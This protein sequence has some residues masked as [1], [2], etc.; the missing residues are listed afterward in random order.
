MALLTVLFSLSV[1]PRLHVVHAMDECL[2]FNGQIVSFT[3]LQ[4]ARVPGE[5]LSSELR[6]DDGSGLSRV[7][8][9]ESSSRGNEAEAR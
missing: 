9:V 4:V 7:Q 2:G 5:N 6:G 1:K 8:A 3:V